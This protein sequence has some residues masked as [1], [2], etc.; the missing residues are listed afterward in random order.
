M[1]VRSASSTAAFS[2]AACPRLAVASDG[3]L[4]AVH[5]PDRVAVLELPGAAPFAEV[6]IDPEAAA[7]DVA[8]VGAP[9]RLLVLS[10]YAAHSTVHL[11]DPYGPRTIAEIR[12]E[13]PMKL[14]ATVGT[15]AL[16]VGALGAAVLTASDTHLTPYQFPARAVPVAAGAAGSQLVVALTG[17][18]EEWDPQSRMP[19]R[20][21]KLPRAGAITAVG[22]SDRVV[23]WT[24]QAEPARLEVSPL[25]NRGQP[26]LHELPE[27]IA[28]VAAHP[29]SDLVACV[30]AE[31]GRVYVV[32]LDGRTGLRV[33][34]AEGIERAEAAALVVGRVVGVLAAQAQHPVALV[35]LDRRDD[36]PPAGS[37]ARAESDAEPVKKSTLYDDPPR[38]APRA[39]TP[40]PV[41]V[42]QAV[43]DW[44]EQR[45]S[46]RDDATAWARQVAAGGSERDAP[47][48]R[49]IDDLALRFELPSALRAALVLLYGAHLAGE[50]GAAPIDVARVLGRR[51]DDALG[52]GLLAGRGVAVYRDSRVRLAPAVLRALD[53][54]APRTGTLVGTPGP[55]ALLGPCVVVAPD[56][57]PLAQVASRALA[58]AGG[59]ILAAHAHAHADPHELALE[60]RAFGAVAMLRARTADGP[61]ILVVA[62]ATALDLP[63]L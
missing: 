10:R 28:H 13:A 57:E 3:T 60:G 11:V 25:V 63:R 51:W 41:P 9:P 17:V 12:L 46:W 22:G 61:C 39:A 1:A 29:R 15:H 32:D 37:E 27:P 18:I 44:P 33:I 20:R 31:S 35:S 30:G 34:G 49:A 5:E 55:I 26:K 2:P 4:A 24:T 8:W 53:E 48:A 43:V 16:A 6:G 40:A 45:P 58:A 38:P 42:A 52:R 62:D 21:I 47:V 50:A 56:D 23:W 54:L 19:K 36:A 14:C 7:S 59:A